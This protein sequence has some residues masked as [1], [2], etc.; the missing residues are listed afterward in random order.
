MSRAKPQLII[1]S[2]LFFIT[3]T[4]FGTTLIVQ[5]AQTAGASFAATSDNTNPS[6]LHRCTN[7][8]PWRDAL[9]WNSTIGAADMCTR[10]MPQIVG[11]VRTGDEIGDYVEHVL[12]PIPSCADQHMSSVRFVFFTPQQVDAFEHDGYPSYVDGYLLYG[13]HFDTQNARWPRMPRFGTIGLS[14]ENCKN[15]NGSAAFGFATYGDCALIDNRRFFTM[16]LGPNTVRHPTFLIRALHARPADERTTLINGRM[17]LTARKP[18][19]RAWI[20][21]AASICGAAGVKCAIGTDW[22]SYLPNARDRYVETLL[23]SLYT[24]CPSGNNFEQYRIWEALFAGSIPIV[25]DVASALA[26]PLYVSPAYGADYHCV[27]A[28]VHAILRASN[29]PVLYATHAANLTHIVRAHNI[30]GLNNMQHDIA[31]WRKKLF[32]HYQHLLFH[33]IHEY[34]K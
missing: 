8:R 9:A 32:T 19:R 31:A 18:S 5:Y 26:H 16:P 22:L 6:R 34:F 27:A 13:G 3:M 21:E 23:D 20:T 12:L 33:L 24:L 2:F 10:R 15:H 25:E 1:A 30:T 4:Y 7:A 29:A 11:A 28:D 14:A 17:T